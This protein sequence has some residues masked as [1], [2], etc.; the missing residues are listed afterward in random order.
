MTQIFH[1]ISPCLIFVRLDVINNGYTPLRGVTLQS[2]RCRRPIREGSEYFTR[3]VG[4]RCGGRIRTSRKPATASAPAR[5]SLGAG[6]EP[7]PDQLE[8]FLVVPV[9]VTR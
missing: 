2:R 1:E 4:P 6:S 5:L 9:V 8:L 7:D 3:Q